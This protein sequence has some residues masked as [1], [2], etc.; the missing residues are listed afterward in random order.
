M[1]LL[2]LCR[3]DAFVV[4]IGPTTPL[5]PVLFEYGVDALCGTV[6]DDPRAVVDRL[7]APPSAAGHRLP[8]THPG[9]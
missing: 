9:S 2:A 1:D 5:S 6:V 4:L 7:A 3:G 8:G